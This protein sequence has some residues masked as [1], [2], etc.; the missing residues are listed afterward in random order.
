MSLVEVGEEQDAP[1]VV[2]EY[3]SGDSLEHK[4]AGLGGRPMPLA[5]AVS[6]AAQ[7]PAR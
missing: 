2:M 6:I 1:Y 4:L 7:S 3:L 5:E